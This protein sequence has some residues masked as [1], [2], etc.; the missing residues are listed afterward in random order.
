MLIINITQPSRPQHY[1]KESYNSNYTNP[2]HINPSTPPQYQYKY[3]NV[4][5]NE[6]GNQYDNY[7]NNY[8]RHNQTPPHNNNNNN[9]QQ[10]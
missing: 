8:S 2:H 7:R 4:S 3:D 6:R 10:N 1:N 9:I 5:V